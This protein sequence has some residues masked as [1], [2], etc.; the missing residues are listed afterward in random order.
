MMIKEFVPDMRYLSPREWPHDRLP[1]AVVTDGMNPATAG[2]IPF[3]VTPGILPANIAHREVRYVAMDAQDRLVITWRVVAKTLNADEYRF[4]TN[5]YDVTSGNIVDQG[6]YVLP[7]GTSGF[8]SSTWSPGGLYLETNNT[9]PILHNLRTGTVVPWTVQGNPNTGFTPSGDHV[10]WTVPSPDKAA[11]DFQFVLADT[12]GVVHDRIT[13]FIRT[14]MRIAPWNGST[15][16][17]PQ[18]FPFGSPSLLTMV[19]WCKPPLIIL[20]R[21]S[22]AIV[23]DMNTGES[24]GACAGTFVHASL[25]NEVLTIM[26]QEENAKKARVFRLVAKASQ[27]VK[28]ASPT[29][30]TT[31]P[32]RDKAKKSATPAPPPTDGPP[33][34]TVPGGLPK[35]PR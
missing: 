32:A 2:C 7:A 35:V 29:S 1:L 28:T 34:F 8:L 19:K 18:E 5:W 11:G 9:R 4:Y 17:E 21:T 10:L 16:A 33:G 3:P 25:Q 6:C 26:T 13:R 24:L 22:S 27:P 31:A 12:E 20:N 30:S 15:L 14:G 23:Y